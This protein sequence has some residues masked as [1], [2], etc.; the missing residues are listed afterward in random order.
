MSSSCADCR[1]NASSASS[2]GSAASNRPSSSISSCPSIAARRGP[3]R[4]RAHARL[5]ASRQARH[6]FRRA[7]EFKLVETLAQRLA[8]LVL[9]EFGLEWVRLS[10]NKP[11]A[12]RGS[13]DVGVRV[14]RTRADLPTPAARLDRMPTVY[15]AAGSNVEPEAQPDEG[16]PRS[17]RMNSPT[18]AS[19]P[20]TAMPRLDSRAR[21]SSTGVA[22]FSTQL[23]LHEVDRAAAGDRD[24]LRPAARC[25]ALGAAHD[26]SRYSAVRRRC[27]A[28]SPA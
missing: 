7:S 11:G 15:I 25:A 26:G 22:G 6:R 21:T 20:G 18:S 3:R 23:A 16:C 13:R 24:A 19:P 12:I 2:T 27:I 14:V 4:S 10:V 28:T 1:S 5:Q 8:M 9:E 17:S